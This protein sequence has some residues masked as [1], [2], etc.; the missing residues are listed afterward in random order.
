[1]PIDIDYISAFLNRDGVEGPRQTTGYIPARPGNFYGKTNQDPARYDAIGVSGVTIGTGV[2]L[3]QTDAESLRGYGVS[4][5]LIRKFEPYLGLS[6][7]RAIYKL[8][9]HPLKITAEEAE[10]LDHAMHMGYLK[11]YVMP[12]YNKYSPKI[13]YEDLPMQ[14]QAVVFSLIYQL[15]AGGVRKNAPMTW[16]YLTNQMWADASHELIYGFKKYSGRRAIEGR[17]LKGLCDE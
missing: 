15:G 1:M 12:T 7:K 2:D 3:G 4:E 8:S 17:L 14:A 9:S 16:Y 6:S 13:R 10:I 5:D 11:R